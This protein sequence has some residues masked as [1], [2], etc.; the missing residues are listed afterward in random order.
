M[1]LREAM[2]AGLPVLAADNPLHRELAAAEREC[3]LLPPDDPAAWAAALNRVLEQ[4]ELAAALGRAARNRAEA[5]FALA[6][7]AAA[8]LTWLHEL[9][10]GGTP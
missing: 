7:T 2:A 4:P 8:H 3:L 10:A 9:H 1:A 5:D 6:R